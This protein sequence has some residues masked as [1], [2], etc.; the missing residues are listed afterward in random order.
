MGCGGDALD[1]APTHTQER[2]P[3]P[4][5]LTEVPPLQAKGLSASPDAWVQRKA[6]LGSSPWRLKIS[7]SNCTLETRQGEKINE[8]KLDREKKKKE[9]VSD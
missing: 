1:S 2:A 4:S 9:R 8:E 5:P 3:W 7:H 6:W